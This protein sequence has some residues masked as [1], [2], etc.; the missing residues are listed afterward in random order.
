MA[1][2]GETLTRLT[3]TDIDTIFRGG[4]HEFIQ[5]IIRANNSLGIQIEKDYRFYA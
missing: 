1:M 4:L 2:C 5:S 3:S